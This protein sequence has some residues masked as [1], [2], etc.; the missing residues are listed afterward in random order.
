M[1]YME[2]EVYVL[3][4]YATFKRENCIKENVVCLEQPEKVST[5]LKT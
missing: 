4:V 5:L 1:N 2:W 3:K